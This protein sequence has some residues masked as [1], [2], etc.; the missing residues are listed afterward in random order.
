MLIRPGLLLCRWSSLAASLLFAFS[1]IAFWWVSWPAAAQTQEPAPAEPSIQLVQPPG[2]DQTVPPVTITLQDALERA[3]RNDAQYLSAVADAQI[4]REDRVQ[5]KAALLPQASSTLQYLGTQGNGVLPSGRFVSN[6]GV[7]MYRAWGV[8]HQD[9]SPATFLM[10]GYKR[11]SA[12]EALAKAK[13]EIAARGLAATVTRNYYAV[14]VS[15]RRY[16]TAQQALQQ[17]QRFFDITRESERL[18]QTAHSDT[19]KAELQYQQQKRAFD[20]AMLAMESDR[21]SLAVLLSPA[22]NL[23]FNIIDDL[24]APRAL[25]AFA[26]A[27]QMAEQEN[28]D[29]RVALET[30]QAANLDVTS[31][32]LSFLPSLA[33]ETD[34][35]I[36]ANAF[37]LHSRVAADPAVGRLPNLGYFI[38]ATLHVPLWDWGALRSK[39]RQTEYRKRQAQSQLS[40]AQRQIVGNL[41]AFYN[42]ASVA[43]SAVETLR[44]AA[45]LAA[46][47]LRLINLRYQAGEST[48]L[49][50]VDAQNTLTQA[51]NAY[52]DAQARYRVAVANLQ[53]VTGAF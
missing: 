5:A 50:V 32:K 47:S 20:E 16:S 8:L 28:P 21:L 6:D 44:H 12:A 36:E 48:A 3:R 9:L 11:A 40:Q 23:N 39:L 35:G 29:L 49:E 33:I 4:A 53:T 30:L 7:H 25:P 13:T 26:E 2:P 46:E 43:R 27:K 18:G 42:E 51:R 38:T 41:Y 10:T 52:D 31:A 17:A 1:L 14:A 34:Y 19:V 37:A 15:Q 24:D 45:D 22:L